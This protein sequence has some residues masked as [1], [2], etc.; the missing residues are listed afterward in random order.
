MSQNHEAEVSGRCA[1]TNVVRRWL[2]RW[3]NQLHRCCGQVWTAWRDEAPVLMDGT[4]GE[5]RAR[6]SQCGNCGGLRAARFTARELEAA[7]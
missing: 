2:V 4:E 3:R 6:V 1:R 7:A 5:P